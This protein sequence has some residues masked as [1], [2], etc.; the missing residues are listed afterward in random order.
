MPQYDLFIRSVVL[1]RERV[2][3]WETYPFCLP[4][5]R[6]LDKLDFTS[7]VTF[8]A[9]ENGSGKSTLLEAIAVNYGFNPEGGSRNFNFSTYETHS[10]LSD[11]LTLWKGAYKAEDGFFLRAESFYNV[12]SEVD[13]LALWE[14]YGGSLHRQS[15][16]ESFMSLLMNRFRGKGMYILDE[17]EA[18]L[19][20]M[21]QLAMIARMR[22][23]AQEG[24]QFIIATHS[25]ILLGYPEADILVLGEDGPVRTPYEETEHYTLTRAFLRHPKKIL[26][27]LFRD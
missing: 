11:F 24:S 18:A 20:P 10:P 1:K 7:R 16:G 9:G 27:E 19:S 23:L 13:R 5:V 8:L 4:V 2:E 26:D 12:A 6:T 15:H 14:S 25:P 3:E 17:P 22:D 21:R